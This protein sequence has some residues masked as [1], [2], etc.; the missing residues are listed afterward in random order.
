MSKQVDAAREVYRKA[1]AKIEK[2]AEPVKDWRAELQTADTEAVRSAD[3]R[4]ECLTRDD[5]KGA[6]QLHAQIKAKQ[7]R[8]ADLK[9]MIERR[10][11]D[12]A[13]A[14]DRLW[15]DEGRNVAMAA[16]E[17]S[18][19][20]RLAAARAVESLMPQW[21]EVTARFEAAKQNEMAIV[22]YESEALNIVNQKRWIDQQIALLKGEALS[23][24][25]IPSWLMNGHNTIGE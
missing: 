6:D 5:V 25:Y 18:I 17:F 15:S 22:G 21:N 1:Y 16:I 7:S 13:T 10:Q 19:A 4:I 23:D 11:S 12:I 9:A 24:V 14:L 2:L 3:R 20:E 8:A